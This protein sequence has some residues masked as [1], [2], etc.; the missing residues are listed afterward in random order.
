MCSIN[1]RERSHWGGK[2]QKDIYMSIAQAIL[3]RKWNNRAIALTLHLKPSA[4]TVQWYPACTHTH[5]HTNTGA[6]PHRASP[7]HPLFPDRNHKG[8]KCDE[9]DFKQSRLLFKE[10]NW[11]VWCQRKI[12]W[13]PN[14]SQGREAYFSWFPGMSDHCCFAITRW[15]VSTSLIKKMDF[16]TGKG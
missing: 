15:Q 3:K 6:H 13:K 5:T 14:P 8:S 16:L 10:V 11:L 12:Q 4:Y 1:L 2:R 7:P 9:K